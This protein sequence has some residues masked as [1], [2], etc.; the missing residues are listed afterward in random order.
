MRF[1]KDCKYVYI[2]PWRIRVHEEDSEPMPEVAYLCQHPSARQ[3]GKQSLVNGER[4]SDWYYTCHACRAVPSGLLCGK[5][6][7]FWEPKEP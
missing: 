7:K 1:C 6:G 4:T 2:E 3:Q 5:E